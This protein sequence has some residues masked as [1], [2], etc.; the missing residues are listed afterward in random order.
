MKK[1]RWQHKIVTPDEARK[2]L[3][4][5]GY[6]AGDTG[7][8]KEIGVELGT[9]YLLKSEIF[10]WRKYKHYPGVKTGEYQIFTE[11]GVRIELWDSI[12][13]E[14][15]YQDEQLIAEQGCNDEYYPYKTVADNATRRLAS[16]FPA[17]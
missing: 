6:D 11:V 14:V 4:E 15:V 16:R 10:S 7:K 3:K 17:H 5:K 13:G 1:I 2:I 8:Y 9:D 12:I